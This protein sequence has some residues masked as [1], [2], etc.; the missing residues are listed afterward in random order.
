MSLS[1]ILAGKKSIAHMF[2]L[3]EALSHNITYNFFNIKV[4]VNHL[5]DSKPIELFIIKFIN[6][7]SWTPNCSFVSLKE[8][9]SG[10]EIPL[11]LQW[12]Q[13]TI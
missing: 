3:Y 2:L 9:L 7:R 8:T 12:L 11:T 6:S 1:D 4:L 5:P 10:K 13:E